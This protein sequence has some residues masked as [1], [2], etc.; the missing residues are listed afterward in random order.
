MHLLW[1]AENLCRWWWYSS[2]LPSP[3]KL[4]LF[5]S[6]ADIFAFQ[7][8]F[9]HKFLKTF[10]K[11]ILNATRGNSHIHLCL[12]LHK[13][14]LTV[15]WGN[16]VKMTCQMLPKHQCQMQ[17]AKCF[18]LNWDWLILFLLNTHVLSLLKARSFSPSLRF[19]EN[20]DS[21]VC[22]SLLTGFGLLRLKLALRLWKGLLNVVILY[23]YSWLPINFLYLKISVI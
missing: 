23:F 13:T 1:T 12:C 22:Y 4:N 17:A 5:V 18:L 9:P 16:L 21:V 10:D 14:S 2:F 20:S 7:H 15:I 11:C 19:T 8:C 6:W 3:P